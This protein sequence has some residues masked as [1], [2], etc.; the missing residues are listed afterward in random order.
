[1]ALSA[2][3]TEYDIG[4]AG[5]NQLPGCFEVKVNSIIPANQFVGFCLIVDVSS[6]AY[7]QNGGDM[8]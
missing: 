6:I 8:L 4:P 1:M 3:K 5:R 7:V 2:G